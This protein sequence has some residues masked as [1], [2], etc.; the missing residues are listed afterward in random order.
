[1]IQSSC[2][3]IISWF[4]AILAFPKACPRVRNYTFT[5]LSVI[6]GNVPPVYDLLQFFGPRNFSCVGHIFER[7][8]HDPCFLSMFINK[9]LL[10][11]TVIVN[12]FS[13]MKQE[14]GPEEKMVL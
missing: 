12:K 11:M 8:S 3:Y 9:P 2:C 4:A 7:K 5:A 6:F 1:M 14:L 13:I 10:R